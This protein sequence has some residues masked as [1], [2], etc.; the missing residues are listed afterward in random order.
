M[1]A[2]VWKGKDQV[3]VENVPDPQIEQPGDV[4]V[5][6][7]TAA[8]CGSDLHMYEE[9][10]AAEPSTVVGH[11]NM[12]VVEDVG[13]GVMSIKKGDRVTPLRSAWSG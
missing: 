5:R 2:V 6:I 7:S 4:I 9:R 8:I 13:S 11:E 10:S 12:G 3:A 1:K